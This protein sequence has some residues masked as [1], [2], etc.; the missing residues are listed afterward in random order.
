MEI[1]IYLNLGVSL[2]A[3]GVLVVNAAPFVASI[4]AVAVAF[5]SL[6]MALYHPWWRWLAVTLGSALT[7]SVGAGIGA[8]LGGA[9]SMF[10]GAALGVLFA[11]GGYAPFVAD[12][13]R[14]MQRDRDAK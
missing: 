5:V 3:G 6:S 8:L 14:A 7:I 2:I 4:V 10:F 12:V 1:A 9:A 13:V 11:A